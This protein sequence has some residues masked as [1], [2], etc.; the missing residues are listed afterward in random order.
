MSTKPRVAKKEKPKEEPKPPIEEES[1]EKKPMEEKAEK[2]TPIIPEEEAVI[3]TPPKPRTLDEKL[4]DI[5]N[6]A[7]PGPMSIAEV[8]LETGLEDPILIK[9]AWDRLYD[10]HMVP[11]SKLYKPEQGRVGIDE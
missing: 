8:M 6:A 9:Q 7:R 10:R 2:P 1:T 5:Y 4:L 3:A 11:F